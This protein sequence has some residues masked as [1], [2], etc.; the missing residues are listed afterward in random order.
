MSTKINLLIHR[1]PDIDLIEYG[2]IDTRILCYILFHPDSQAKE[3]PT[4]GI[5][6]TGAP[7]SLIPRFIWTKLSPKII[8]EESYLSGVIPG[9]SHMMMTKIGIISAKLLGKAG[10]HYPVSFPA[11]LAPINRVP[12]IIGMQSILEKAMIHIDVNGNNNWLEFK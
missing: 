4:V 6:D 3:E 12:I 2:V 1:Q 7:M 10:N 8:Q 11:H 5:I 9:P